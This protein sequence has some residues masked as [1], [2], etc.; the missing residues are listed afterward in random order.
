M[1]GNIVLLAL[2]LLS[3]I[4]PGVEPDAAHC[5]SAK[6]YLIMDSLL[7]AG[8]FCF[9]LVMIFI[10]CGNPWKGRRCE[11][12]SLKRFL[13]FRG[14]WSCGYFLAWFLA[15]VT[16]GQAVHLLLFRDWKNGWLWTDA[17]GCL[18]ACAGL[19]AGHAVGLMRWKNRAL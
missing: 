10:Q 3:S 9:Q 1:Y 7:F 16:A 19:V 13:L 5:F 17:L 6:G 4:V 14:A 2:F 15:A 11:R 12:P 18:A 8:C